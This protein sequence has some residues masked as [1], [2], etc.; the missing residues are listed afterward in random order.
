V[1]DIGRLAHKVQ[2]LACRCDEV[3]PELVDAAYTGLYRHLVNPLLGDFVG[4]D[5]GHSMLLEA[6]EAL[7]IFLCL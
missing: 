7:H 4:D 3:L 1:A 2:R 5:R 6:L